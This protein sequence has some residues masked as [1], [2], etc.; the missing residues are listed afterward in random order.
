MMFKSAILSSL[1]LGVCSAVSVSIV[2]HNNNGDVVLNKGYY[3]YQCVDVSQISTA[4]FWITN[5]AGG[6]CLALWD[7]ASCNGN[8]FAAASGNLNFGSL[9]HTFG[10]TVSGVQIYQC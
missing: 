1:V 4:E 8:Q 5:N 10:H 7:G 2:A 9:V 6:S 3:S